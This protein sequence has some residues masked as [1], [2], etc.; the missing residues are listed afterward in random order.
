MNDRLHGII[1]PCVTPFSASDE[2]I[3]IGGLEHNFGLWNQTGVAG[4]M[5][6]GTNGEFKNLSDEESRTVVKVAAANKGDKTLIV[7]A[8]RESV[9]NTVDFIASL[10]PWYDQIDYISV[11]T[12]NYFPKLMD[13]AALSEYYTTVADASPLPILIYVIPGQA[14]GV[15]VP[16]AVLARLA[17]HPNIAGVKDTSPAMLVDYMLAAG[18]RDD[19]EVLAG[20]LNNIMTALSFGGVGGVVSAANYLPA[21]C[22]RLTDLYFNHSPEDAHRYYREL[23]LVAKAGGGK[24][25]VASVKSAMNARGYRAGVPRRPLL[26]VSDS[27]D[28][29]IRDALTRGLEELNN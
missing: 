16:P 7:G 17:D 22:A 6:L 23:Q 20:S 28:A 9:R 11:L 14:N 24:R 3:D 15:V 4:Y 21:E 10:A 29:V 26:P 25:G 8:G 13:G 5:V 2:A 1:I 12:P 19:F 27:D 18:D